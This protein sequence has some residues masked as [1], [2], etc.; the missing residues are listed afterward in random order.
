MWRTEENMILAVI[1]S[2]SEKGYQSNKQTDWL[3]DRVE[4]LQDELMR[5]RKHEDYLLEELK[6]LG[7]PNN[8]F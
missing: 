1:K 3:I 2:N 6:K 7:W 4:K 8:L 5:Q